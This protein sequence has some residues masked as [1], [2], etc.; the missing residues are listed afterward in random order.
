MY[1]ARL[2]TGLINLF[3]G[4]AEICLGLRV[5]FRLFAANPGVQFVQW[6]YSTSDTLLSPFRGIFPAGRIAGGHVLDFTALFGMLIYALF[7]VVLVAILRALAP[8]KT[9]TVKHS[10][11]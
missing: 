7:G 11:K 10:K 4:L 3:V 9:A 6:I 1:I 2:F 8:S 5:L